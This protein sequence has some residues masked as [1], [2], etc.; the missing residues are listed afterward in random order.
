MITST[1]YRRLEPQLP[2]SPALMLAG[3]VD[4]QPAEPVG[5]ELREQLEASTE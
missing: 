5:D 3:T 4:E 1:A 2:K